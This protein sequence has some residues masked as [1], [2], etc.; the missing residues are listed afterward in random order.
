M[1]YE[2]YKKERQDE[3]NKLP[4]FFAFGN[5]QF[6]EAMEERGLTENDTDK[7]YSLGYGGYYLRSDADIIR[8][9]F[10]KPDKLPELMQD[11]DFCKSA[12]LYEMGN[13]EY[14]I[15]WQADYDVMSCFGDI[16]YTDSSDE[17][18]QYFDTLNWSDMQRKAYLDARME[19]YKKAEENGYI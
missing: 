15:N 3:F 19:Y 6:R 16:K 4:I 11:Y 12:V 8:G 2:E 7:I 13:H 14:C 17:L 10:N 5:D 9:Y 18:K 1:N